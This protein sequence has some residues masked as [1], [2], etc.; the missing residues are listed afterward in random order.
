MKVCLLCGETYNDPIDFCFRDGEVLASAASREAPAHRPP[1][2]TYAP[3]PSHVVGAAL[4]ADEPEV[5]RA[6]RRALMRAA[7]AAYLVTDPDSA[8]TDDVAPSN[9]AA[10]PPPSAMFVPPLDE[11]MPDLPWPLE[12]EIPEEVEPPRGSM[13]AAALI[14]ALVVVAAVLGAGL[15]VLVGLTQREPAPM[16]ASPVADERS[17][18][19]E[20]RFVPQDEER[21]PTPR[22][23]T[24]TDRISGGGNVADLPVPADPTPNLAPLAAADFRVVLGDAG[25]AGS[26]PLVLY[27]D[28]NRAGVVPVTVRLTPGEHTFRVSTETSGTAMLEVRRTVETPSDSADIPVIDLAK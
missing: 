9:G 5:T 4:A 11:G 22:A 28:G 24:G 10:A 27:V 16:R 6:N 1:S 2:D 3:T 21:A 19:P 15:L 20:R 25:A 14:G 23:I 12:E 13:F 18:L 17:S 8:G 7:A 26:T